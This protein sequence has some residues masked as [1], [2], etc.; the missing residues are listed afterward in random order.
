MPRLE[1]PDGRTLA[2]RE[3]GTGPPLLLHPGGPGCSSRY[4]GELPELAAERTL[5]LLDP[6]GTGDSDRP[7]DPAAYDLEDYADDIELV[8]D[9]LGLERIDLVGHSHGGFVAVNWAGNH[10]NRVGRLVLAST[11][12]RFTDEIREA[13]AR[14]IESHRG[15]PYFEDALEALEIHQQGRYSS[16]EEVAD[17]FRRDW[18]L[19]L[20]PHIDYGPIADG[21]ARAGNNA[22]VLRH[23]NEV[24]AGGMDQRALLERIEAPTLVLTTEL[25]PFALA[26]PEAAD[27][28][29]DAT[30]VELPGADHFAFLEAE[31]R[32]AW[33]RAILDFLSSTS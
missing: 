6:R 2:W 14:R 24:I 9:H 33:C 21:L 16:D 15:Q 26:G 23:F 30:L 31:N 19:Q 17:L 29:P 1:A 13:R 27:H 11:A 10:P 12:P 20:A 8:R 7:T 5:L 22:D 25:D 18:R 4:F 3:V 32:P 28:L